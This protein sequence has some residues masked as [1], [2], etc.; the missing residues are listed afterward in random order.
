MQT[1]EFPLRESQVALVDRGI[2]EGRILR[3]AKG[4]SKALPRFHPRRNT[5]TT[6]LYQKLARL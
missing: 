5:G 4:R 3:L 2:L 1:L 6:A